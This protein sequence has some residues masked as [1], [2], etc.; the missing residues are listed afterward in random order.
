MGWIQKAKEGTAKARAQR[1]GPGKGTVPR[2]AFTVN[3]SPELT[4]LFFQPPSWVCGM[5]LGAG[6][7]GPELAAGSECAQKGL[8]ARG[9]K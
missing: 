6:K 8:V 5:G 1:R 4:E 3:E 7:W 2:A 9:G